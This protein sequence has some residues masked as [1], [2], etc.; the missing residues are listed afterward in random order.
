MPLTDFQNSNSVSSYRQKQPKFYVSEYML[1][2]KNYYLDYFEN[3]S[4]L[5]H[6]INEHN[7]DFR[8]DN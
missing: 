3:S 6:E 7:K 8:S 1:Q 4:L 2:L 5:R